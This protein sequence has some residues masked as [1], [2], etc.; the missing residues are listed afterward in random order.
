MDAKIVAPGGIEEILPLLVVV[1]DHADIAVRG[2]VGPPVRRQMTGI[3]ALV[4][5]RLVG[6]TAHVIAHHEAGH[7]FEHRYIDA[8]AAAGTVTVDKGGADRT[9]G[10]E[11]DNTVDQRIRDIA[12]HAVGGLRHQRR[13]CRRALDQIVIGGLRRIGPILAEAEHTGIDQ[14]RVDFRYDVV[15]KIQPRHGLRAH[16][17]YQHV[18]G[19]DQPQ[20]SVAPGGLLQIETN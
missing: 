10:R 1:D 4:E 14:A 2:L 18:G 5:R 20:H 3:A 7:G 19:F 13:Q 6:E 17:V 15:T 9:H 8:L 12:R 16:V 11:P